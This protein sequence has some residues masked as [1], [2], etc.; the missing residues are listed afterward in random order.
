MCKIVFLFVYFL[1]M[2]GEWNSLNYYQ[3]HFKN[4]YILNFT[5]LF[6]KNVCNI[7]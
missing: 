5:S 1:Q 3:E 7:L 4:L 2:I 6:I